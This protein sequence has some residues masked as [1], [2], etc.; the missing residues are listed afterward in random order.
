MSNE[1][2]IKGLAA[3]A[4]SCELA[5]VR[6]RRCELEGS[7]SYSVS[8]EPDEIYWLYIGEVYNLKMFVD[9]IL[10][11]FRQIIADLSLDGIDWVRYSIDQYGICIEV[12]G[13]NCCS[14]RPGI[15]MSKGYSCHNVDNCNQAIALVLFL[16]AYLKSAYHFIRRYL[17]SKSAEEIGEKTNIRNQTFEIKKPL[18]SYDVSVWSYAPD[19]F[20][21][22][23]SV[24]FTARNQ[25]EASDIAHKHGG[26]ATRSFDEP[27]RFY[28][29]LSLY[30]ITVEYCDDPDSNRN[31]RVIAAN[32]DEAKKV[33]EEELQK[34]LSFNQTTPEISA[35]KI[36]Q[37]IDRAIILSQ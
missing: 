18:S 21:R 32:E 12:P 11:K 37:V 4:F 25:D 23:Q 14:V 34:Q 5:I 17:E 28:Y 30:E 13:V 19:T 15:S 20:D 22:S 16:S 27:G 10:N 1:E 35:R 36:D 31:F 6:W 9:E 29:D 24:A 33:V 8:C 3:Q 26:F 2:I 7:V